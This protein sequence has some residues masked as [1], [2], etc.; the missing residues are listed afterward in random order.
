MTEGKVL[1]GEGGIYAASL[2]LSQAFVNWHKAFMRVLDPHALTYSQWIIMQTL[3]MSGQAMTPTELTRYLT[4]EGTSISVVIDG[5]GR[6]GLIQRRR[7][8]TDRRMVKVSL[9][10]Q[11]RTL[12]EEIDAAIAALIKEIYGPLTAAERGQLIR[13]CRKVRDA[14]VVHNGGDPAVVEEILDKF[15]GTGGD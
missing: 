9:T 3:S 2:I 5:I 12:L 7:S 13:L 8:R 15:S 1:R 6:R 11:G 14:S 10:E 4:I